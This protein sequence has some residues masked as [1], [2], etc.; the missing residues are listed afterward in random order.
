MICS[1]SQGIRGEKHRETPRILSLT[2]SVSIRFC[3]LNAYSILTWSW[4]MTIR[5]TKPALQPLHTKHGR[6]GIPST[7]RTPGN[8]L[9]VSPNKLGF[10]Q[11][12]WRLSGSLVAI[13]RARYFRAS[14][15][16]VRKTLLTRRFSNSVFG[17]AAKVDCQIT[18]AYLL[19]AR[20]RPRKSVRASRRKEG[21]PA[22]SFDADC[23]RRAV[24]DH[25]R[26]AGL[27]ISRS[28]A[29]SLIRT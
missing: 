17:P 2:C 29:S 24:P 7:K 8:K 11:G 23:Q 25:Q 15:K 22:V 4:P 28:A 1:V 26:G 10:S 13:D 27:A 16:Q 9:P 5:R 6:S 20:E 21:K 12:S 3:G 19:R 18:F 14:T